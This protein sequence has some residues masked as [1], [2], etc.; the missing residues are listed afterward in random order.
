MRLY[1]FTRVTFWGFW[2]DALAVLPSLASGSVTRRTVRFLMGASA[3]FVALQFF[4][5]GQIVQQIFIAKWFAKPS[6]DNAAVV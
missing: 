6:D 4:W 5:F 2:P 3:S 1:L